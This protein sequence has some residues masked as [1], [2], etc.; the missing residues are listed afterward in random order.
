MRQLIEGGRYIREMVVLSW[1]GAEV[2]RKCDNAWLPGHGIEKLL[3]FDVLDNKRK[4]QLLKKAEKLHLFGIVHGNLSP[5]NVLVSALGHECPGSGA[6]S[7]LLQFGKRFVCSLRFHVLQE[8]LKLIVL[9]SELSFLVE[10]F[11]SI[12]GFLNLRILN[13]YFTI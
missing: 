12:I 8:I 2:D 11:I 7:E 3:S 9:Y 5:E 13:I 10:V 1:G 6:C 4:Y